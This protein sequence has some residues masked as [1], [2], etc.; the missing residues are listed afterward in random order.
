MSKG[1]R[2]GTSFL[3]YISTIVGSTMVPL[4]ETPVFES[5][6]DFGVLPLS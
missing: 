3:N 4:T 5:R 2:K 1:K 6:L